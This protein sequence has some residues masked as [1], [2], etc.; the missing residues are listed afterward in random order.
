M[1]VL[2]QKARD[3]VEQE[4]WSHV[5]TATAAQALEPELKSVAPWFKRRM[6]AQI[7]QRAYD[8]TRFERMKQDFLPGYRAKKEAETLARLIGEATRAG[9]DPNT[10]AQGMSS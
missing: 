6:A 8:K 1:D 9:L 5:S 3:Y 10:E 2:K 4:T 7:S